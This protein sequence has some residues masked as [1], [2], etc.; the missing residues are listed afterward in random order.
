MVTSKSAGEVAFVMADMA[1]S[2]MSVEE[3]IVVINTR[4]V[5]LCVWSKS[6]GVKNE[7]VTFQGFQ[8]QDSPYVSTYSQIKEKMMMDD[9]YNAM[10][11][12]FATTKGQK[13]MEDD[14]EC[15]TMP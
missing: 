12:Y 3:V 14:V 1:D 5:C 15:Y 11:S 7:T 4:G 13:E 2:I 8:A 10:K 6:S 9:C